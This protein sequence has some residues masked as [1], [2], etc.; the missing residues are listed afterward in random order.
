M[1]T[2]PWAVESAQFMH[3][4]SG[5]DE[6]KLGRGKL[7]NIHPE[8]LEYV[9]DQNLGSAGAFVRR[10]IHLPSKLSEGTAKS[11]DIP[12]VRRFVKDKTDYSLGDRF[13]EAVDNSVRDKVDNKAMSI[14]AKNF[15]KLVGKMW[16]IYGKLKEAG[17]DAKAKKQI[18]AITKKQR[19]FL[20]LYNA[21]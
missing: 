18:E 16:T 1:G 2:D 8:S 4:L 20:K 12:F 13:K 21:E 17:K 3:Y 7:A 19:Q 6:N 11:S 15:D 9:L 14:K 5:G 10:L